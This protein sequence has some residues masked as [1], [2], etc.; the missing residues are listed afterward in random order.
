RGDLSLPPRSSGKT[1]GE[2]KTTDEKP[3]DTTSTEKATT[4]P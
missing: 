3:S 1:D 4:A 2:T